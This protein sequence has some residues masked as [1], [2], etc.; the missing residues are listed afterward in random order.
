MI[1]HAQ[2]SKLIDY[3]EYGR[4]RIDNYLTGNV[5]RPSVNGRENRPYCDTVAGADGCANLYSLIETA[6]ANC[7]EACAYLKPVF[8]ELP[9]ATSVDEIEALLSVMNDSADAARVS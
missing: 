8:T 1:D 6:K 2:W 9:S 5:I 4:R 7:I 3:V